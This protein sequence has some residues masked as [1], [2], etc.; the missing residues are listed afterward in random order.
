M[1]QIGVYKRGGPEIT[2]KRLGWAIS[3]VGLTLD[4]PIKQEKCQPTVWAG[5]FLQPQSLAWC[6]EDTSHPWC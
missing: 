1:N 2:Q 3:R 5:V 4:Q 6:L